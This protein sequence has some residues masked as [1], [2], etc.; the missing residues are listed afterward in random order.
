MVV[1]KWLCCLFATQLLASG[2]RA[3]RAASC[4]RHRG[5]V[6]RHWAR[7]FLEGSAAG[8]SVSGRGPIHV[9]CRTLSSIRL[10]SGN[11]APSHS[12]ARSTQMPLLSKLYEQRRYCPWTACAVPKTVRAS[13]S[14]A[15]TMGEIFCIVRASDLRSQYSASSDSDQMKFLT[16]AASPAVTPVEGGVLLRTSHHFRQKGQTT[17]PLIKGLL[18]FWHVQPQPQTTAV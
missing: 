18:R 5:R 17:P 15:L 13:S 8:N 6:L 16:V 1:G 3:G 7:P 4:H 12:V 9:Y 2:Q 10:A 11:T 14:D